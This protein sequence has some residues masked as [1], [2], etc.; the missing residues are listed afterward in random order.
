MIANR[1]IPEGKLGKGSQAKIQKVKDS[2]TGTYYALKTFADPEEAEREIY[3]LERLSASPGLGCH[4]LVPCYYGRIKDGMDTAI[5]LEY[6]KGYTLEEFLRYRKI[7][8]TDIELIKL[9]KYLFEGL[10]YIH[11]KGIVHNDIHTGNVMFNEEKMVLIDFG[12]ACF[13]NDDPRYRCIPDEF[14]DFE[15][16]EILRDTLLYPSVDIMQ[17]GLMLWNIVNKLNGDPYPVAITLTSPYR[18]FIGD[19][20]TATDRKV[21]YDTHRGTIIDE[22]QRNLDAIP[23]VSTNP[24]IVNLIRYI[25]RVDPRTRPTAADIV[26]LVTKT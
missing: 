11:S 4:P 8:M 3:I 18:K 15:T 21:F 20:N 22:L 17:T 26:A 19:L 24:A 9:S 2:I 5:I 16:E 14:F 1:Y 25:V 12:L 13:Y 6:I 10:A 7:K 23:V